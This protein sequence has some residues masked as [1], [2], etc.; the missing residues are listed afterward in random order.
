[1]KTEIVLR[2]CKRAHSYLLSLCSFRFSLRP[3]HLSIQVSKRLQKIGTATSSCSIQPGEPMTVSMNW[4]DSLGG[5][6]NAMLN[7]CDSVVGQAPEESKKK[8][9]YRSRSSPTAKAVVWNSRGFRNLIAS[10]VQNISI[11]LSGYSSPG[12]FHNLAT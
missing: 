8:L 5:K 12:H 9:I 10:R 11:G 2:E 7:E 4:C 6:P 1:M 3:L